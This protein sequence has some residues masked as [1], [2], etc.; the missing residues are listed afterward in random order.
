[1][2]P[3][4]MTSHPPRPITSSVVMSTSRIVRR[5]I[6]RNRGRREID[7]YRRRA[8]APRPPSSPQSQPA[9]SPIR[10]RERFSRALHRRDR[11]HI[12]TA[13]DRPPTQT[14]NRAAARP[15]PAS[16]S[17][18]L[19]HSGTTSVARCRLHLRHQRRRDQIGVVAD[20]IVRR[21]HA[22]ASAGL[23]VASCSTS[24]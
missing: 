10:N 13:P 3:T 11:E 8:R 5:R 7:R 16:S 2:S 21:G 12:A 4:R 19:R 18:V 23:E 14:P 24:I 15:R 20:E 1:M 6:Q 17:S 22:A 9:P